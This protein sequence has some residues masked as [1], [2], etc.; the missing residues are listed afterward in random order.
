MKAMK[1]I[2]EFQTRYVIVIA[3][4]QKSLVLHV[5]WT[6]GVNEGRRMARQYSR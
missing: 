4:V 6:G 3:A 1:A 5:R 2:R